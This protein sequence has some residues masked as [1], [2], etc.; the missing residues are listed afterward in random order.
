MPVTTLEILETIQDE[1]IRKKAI[2]NA[3]KFGTLDMEAAGHLA[4]EITCCFAWDCT[5]EGATYWINI[6][7]KLLE[8][9]TI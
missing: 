9:Q 6:Y 5:P 3:K 4:I 8:G 1:E 7:E 2:A